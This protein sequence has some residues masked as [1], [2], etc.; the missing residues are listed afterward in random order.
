[1]ESLG[2]REVWR[3][4]EEA[5]LWFVNESGD[6]ASDP[7]PVRSLSFEFLRTGGLSGDVG[8]VELQSS[9]EVCPETRR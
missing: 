6:M 7:D 1:M 5:G 3:F 2:R 8:P 9:S 4:K